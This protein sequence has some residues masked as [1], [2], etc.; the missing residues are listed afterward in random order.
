MIAALK[1]HFQIIILDKL[2]FARRLYGKFFSAN[3]PSTA[4][5][6]RLC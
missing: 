4:K 5:H 2:V 6:I 1:Y 3:R